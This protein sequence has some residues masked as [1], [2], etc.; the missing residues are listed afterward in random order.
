MTYIPFI[1]N[2]I[3]SN[4]PFDIHEFINQFDKQSDFISESNHLL[5]FNEFYK[6]NQYIIIPRLIQASPTIMIMSYE[7]GESF[8]N[9]TLS[10]Y[11]KYKLVTLFALFIRNNQ[12]ILNYNHGDLHKG[13]W[14]IKLCENNNH[15]I[16]IY[17]YGFCWRLSKDKEEAIELITETFESSDRTSNKIDIINLSNILEY[18]IIY[19]GNNKEE[20]KETINTF[21]SDRIKDF[22]MHTFSPIRLFKL[23][24]EFCLQENILIDPILI[25]C[26]I[27]AIQG[28]VLLEE[29]GMYSTK[30]NE[31]TSYKV[32]RERYLDFMT[33]CKTYDIF[34]EYITHLQNY[35]NKKQIEVNGMFDCIEMSE[36]IKQLAL[37]K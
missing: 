3:N 37:C 22:E 12:H 35:L 1:R 18:L 17:D 32:Y 30:D 4:F 24:I 10:D 5:Y 9:L 36:E 14:K 26:V 7:E 19:E 23:T 34:P 11:H 27:I 29:F 20:F 8:D 31:I 25:Q 16:I 2:R 13:N 15:K 6:D 21:I 33:I 28:Q